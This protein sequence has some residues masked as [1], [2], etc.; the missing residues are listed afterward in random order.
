MIECK[1]LPTSLSVDDVYQ[2][3]VDPTCGGICLFVGTARDH[4][5]GKSVIRLEFEVYESMAEKLLSEIATECASKYGVRRVVIHHR[6]GPVGITDIAVIIGVSSAHR[7]AAF[8]ACE[9]AIDQLKERVPIWKR[10]FLTDG[11]YWVGTRP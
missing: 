2:S 6:S 7:A 5:K 8:D 4:N 11:S 10:E 3:V 9:Y 1:I